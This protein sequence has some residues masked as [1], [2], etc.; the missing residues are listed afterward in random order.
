MACFALLSCATA[1]ER[2]LVQVEGVE[3]VVI[4]TKEEGV[5][6]EAESSVGAEAL[7][8]AIAAAGGFE[9]RIVGPDRDAG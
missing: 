5:T 8:G 3:R 4:D 1:I 2:A 9:V 7:K 6:V